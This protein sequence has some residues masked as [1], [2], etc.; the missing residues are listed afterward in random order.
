MYDT[1]VL[2]I[3]SFDT[4]GASAM[5]LPAV[6]TFIKALANCNMTTGEPINEDEP[7]VAGYVNVRLSLTSMDVLVRSLLY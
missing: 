5:S 4:L 6:Q 3:G 1:L 7:G 2:Q